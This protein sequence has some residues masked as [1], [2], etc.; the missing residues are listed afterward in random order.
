[1]L[2]MGIFR[3]KKKNKSKMALIC[4][5]ND[6]NS[7]KVILLGLYRNLKFDVIWKDQ[8]ELEQTL[9]HGLKLT[10]HN[11][12]PLI[13]DGDFTVSGSASVLTYFNIKGGAPSL[14]PKKARLLAE[15]HYWI[16]LLVNHLEPPL[17]TNCCD[18]ERVTQFLT[19]V[20]DNLSSRSFFVGEFSLADIHWYVACNELLKQGLLRL[21][22]YT[23]IMRWMEQVDLKIPDSDIKQQLYAA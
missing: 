12:Y 5:H 23:N 7:T 9:S 22:N 2:N 6:F 11:E 1:M 20:N 15:Q 21:K 17:I 3:F 18:E 14:L 4:S 13:N 8:N 19:H 16:E 10:S